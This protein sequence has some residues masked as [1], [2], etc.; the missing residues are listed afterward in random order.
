MTRRWKAAVPALGFLILTVSCSGGGSESPPAAGS[1]AGAPATRAAPR[2]TLPPRTDLG[3]IEGHVAL[4]GR[5][6]GNAVIRMGMDPKCAAITQGEMV[7]QEEVAANADGDLANVFV[8]VD[9][10][11]P[12]APAPPSEPVEIDQKG[13]VYTPRVVGVQVGQTL[14]FLNSDDLPHNVH[15]S[16]GGNAIFN[17]GQPRA[18][19]VHSFVPDEPEMML[20]VACDLHRWMIT[21]V[22]V[23][24]H[25]Y[26]DVSDRAGMFRI[27]GVPAGTYTLH[28]WHEV[29]G[30]LTQSVEVRQDETTT[31]DFE[32]M[33]KE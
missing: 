16:A 33:A 3:T 19:M 20:R 29:Y 10:D 26:F 14:N 21:Y 1:G 15:A 30:E 31:V 28:T 9:G 8:Q 11:F 22:G 27:E 7:V 4:L 13:C 23:V 32:Y 24:A 2:P 12:A 25:P 17:V 5:A 6:P 18:G